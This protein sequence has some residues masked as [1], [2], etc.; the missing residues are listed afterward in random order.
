MT[1]TPTPP[2]DNNRRL[3]EHLQDSVST[4]QDAMV[5][6]IEESGRAYA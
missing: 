1:D 2:S 6:D 3:E 4:Q 5:R